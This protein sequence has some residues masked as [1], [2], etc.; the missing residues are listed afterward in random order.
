MQKTFCAIWKK[1][2]IKSAPGSEWGLL[3]DENLKVTDEIAHFHTDYKTSIKFP[4]PAHECAISC[5]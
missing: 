2:L 5:S 1:H 4:D 3:N